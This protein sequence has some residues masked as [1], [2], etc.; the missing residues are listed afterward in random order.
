[1][2]DESLRGRPTSNSHNDDGDDGLLGFTS[3]LRQPLLSVEDHPDDSV[4]GVDT[5]Q[6]I[7]MTTQQPLHVPVD[8]KNIIVS[9]CGSRRYPVNHNVLLTLLVD[10]VYGISESLW[11][12]T[13]FA[14]YIKKIGGG[15]N[16]PVGNIEAINGLAVLLSALPVGYLADRYG[17]SKVIFAGGV[18]IVITASLHIWLTH[19]IGVDVDTN[20]ATQPHQAQSV[21]SPQTAL[22]LTLLAAVMGLW[23]VGG[24][25]VSGPC[26]ALY[27]DSTPAGDRSKYYH[28]MFVCYLLASCMGPILSIILFQT[29]GDD[30]DLQSLQIIIY[31]GLGLELVNAILMMFF[32]D[33][34]A[35]DEGDDHNAQDNSTTE[36]LLIRQPQTDPELQIADIDMWEESDAE[37]E[38]AN[39][40]SH[41][42]ECLQTRRRWIPYI[43]LMSG[44]I[45]AIG[46]GMT[47]K[48]F[49]LFFKDQVGMSPTQVQ[50]IYV[51][52]PIVMAIFS[53]LGT[54]VASWFGRVQTSLVLQLTG[55]ACLVTMVAFQP[56]L[57][58]EHHNTSNTHKILLVLI[59]VL[60]TALMNAPYPLQES[61]LMDF[62]PK[63][64]R[65][66]WK[67][68]ESIS[69]FGW[70]GSAA[71]GGYLSDKYDYTVTF[72]ITACIQLIGTLSLV[73]LLPLVP[74]REQDLSNTTSQRTE[75]NE[76]QDPVEE[77]SLLE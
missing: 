36:P 25:I 51:L 52:V 76:E 65:A 38:N 18:L 47:V 75:D 56:Y 73:L 13:V 50:I 70:C 59:Y 11:G 31:V 26:Q 9:C 40:D 32:D 14:A 48:F 64:E 41:G 68:L 46:S 33:A 10:V 28:Y 42:D 15:Q 54:S 39:D 57:D 58:G 77:Q 24:G 61:I 69:A 27:A 3:N 19:W 16:G 37:I 22:A 5:E 45:M 74:S 55:V 12:G 44:T 8:T 4:S 7:T 62:V 30:W 23:G 2:K 53:G 21:S 35:L 71:L 20:D 67:S 43:L 72:F 6:S 34:K 1:M 49:P 17:R 66:R 60:R 29:T 63:H